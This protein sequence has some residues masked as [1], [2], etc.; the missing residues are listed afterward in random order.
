MSSRMSV[1]EIVAV[2]MMEVSELRKQ[3]ADSSADQ[4]GTDEGVSPEAREN[5]NSQDNNDG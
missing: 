3:V 4:S 5:E 2:A 1:A